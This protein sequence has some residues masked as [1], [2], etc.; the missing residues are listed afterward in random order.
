[1]STC[2]DFNSEFSLRDPLAIH[3][4]DRQPLAHAVVNQGSIHLEKI[5]DVAFNGVG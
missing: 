5:E 1:M 3:H 2:G 4:D